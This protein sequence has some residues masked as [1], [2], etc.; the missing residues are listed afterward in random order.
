MTQKTV[1]ISINASWNIVNFRTGLVRSLQ[2]A[3]YRV[4]ALAPQ[5]AYSAR[6]EALGIDYIPLPMD[7][8]GL[9]PLRD[10]LLLWRYYRALRR[11]RPDIFLGYTAKPNIYGSLAAHALGIKMINNVS[12]L[13]TAFIRE[14]FLTRIV[15]S[16]YK[17]AFRRS[18]TVFFQN[19]DDRDMFLAAAIVKAGQA[20]L[21]P[22]S[23]VDLDRFSP[24]YPAQREPGGFRFL[25]IARLLWFKGVGEYVE[26]AR[27]VREKV[28][29]VRFQLL[30]FIDP[31]NG[32]AVPRAD[33]DKWVA[34]G[35]I[36]YLGEADDVRP[37]IAAADCVVLPSYRE[38]LPRTLLEAA[39]MG[40]PLIATDVPG[41]RHVVDHDVNG[42][43]CSPRDSVSL[44]EAMLKMLRLSAPRIAE[45]GVA[46]RAKAHAE[47]DERLAINLYLEAIEAAL[48]P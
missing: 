32:N 14:D 19:R 30:G 34:E 25:L 1:L 40:K 10:L 7:T 12:G 33:I 37:F 26:A 15:T 9:S 45:M 4:V 6:F 31:A 3:G 43:L 2:Q 29:G 36:E 17:L 5:D 21:L 27:F 39:A 48:T 13:G 42:L 23:G 18:A 44:A 41:C 22:G 47:F 35:T 38:G 16:L 46:A 20:K 28:P 11:L 8:Q 24:A